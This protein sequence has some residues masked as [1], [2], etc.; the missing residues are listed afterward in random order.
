[1][2]PHGL[3]TCGD[4]SNPSSGGNTNPVHTTRNITLNISTTNN[5]LVSGSPFSGQVSYVPSSQNFQG[6]ISVP[7]LSPGQYLVN[8]KMDGF[9]GK[10]IPTVISVIQGKQ[11]DLPELY[12]TTGDINNDNQLDIEDYNILISCYGS[13]YTTSS[14]LAPATSKSPGADIDDDGSVNGSDYNLFL[15][16]LSVQK[17]G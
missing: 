5:N 9:L 3:G 2:C 4:N 15:R 17:G 12:V 6:T 10:Q 14:C 11:V 1:M 8:V 7:N 16:E 13:K